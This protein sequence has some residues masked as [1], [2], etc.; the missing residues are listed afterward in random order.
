MRMGD[1]WIRIAFGPGVRRTAGS[2][3]HRAPA[4]RGIA[5]ES[6]VDNQN[7]PKIA[8]LVPLLVIGIM[9][10]TFGIVFQSAGAL[11]WVMMG[12][13]LLLMLVA[14]VRMLKLRDGK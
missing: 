10:N 7:N 1:V 6:V 14:L 3:P 12:T 9:L 2:S 13:G 5:P 11:R 8:A 4:G